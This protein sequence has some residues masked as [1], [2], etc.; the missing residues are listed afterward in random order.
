M[1]YEV[2]K[3]GGTSLKDT[4]CRKQAIELI[5]KHSQDHAV[6]VVVSAM[7]R[8]DDA[9]ATDTLASLIKNFVSKKEKD[10]LLSIGEIISSIVLCDELLA[11]GVVATSLSVQKAGIMT[12]NRY[13]EASVAFVKTESLYEALH[14]YHIVVVPGFQGLSREQEIT[15][16]GRGGSDY[17]AVILARALSLKKATIYSDVRGIYSGDPKTIKNVMLLPEIS[18]DQAIEIAKYK[19]NVINENAINYAKKYHIDL[20]LKSTFTPDT[21][22]IVSQQATSQHC[23]C[24]ALGYYEIAYDC[25]I[26]QD[27]LKAQAFILANEHYIFEGAKLKNLH[28]PYTLLGQYAMIHF[29]GFK[30]DL[31]PLLKTMTKF[32]FYQAQNDHNTYF[33]LEKDVIK[34]LNHWHDALILEKENQ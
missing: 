21:G 12:D 13:G 31:Y 6:V 29:V 1:N 23:I 5:K 32:P 19:A 14:D 20:I 11:Q 3:F 7:G 4:N 30:E 8:Y 33:V 28:T 17:S 2:I 9:Y 22:T 15:T 25:L 24:Y 26:S 27:D 34:V 18:Y 10:R 16:L